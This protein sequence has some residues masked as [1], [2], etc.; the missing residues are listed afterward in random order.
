MPKATFKILLIGETQ[1]GC[2]TILSQFKKSYATEKNENKFGTLNKNKEKPKEEKDKVEEEEIKS[3]KQIVYHEN[4]K[5]MLDIIDHK[6]INQTIEEGQEQQEQQEQNTNLPFEDFIKEFHG[7]ILVYD[8]TKLSSS[9]KLKE[10]YELINKNNHCNYRSILLI[11]NKND[12][13]DEREITY[14][15]GEEFAENFDCL[16][17]EISSKDMIQLDSAITS[18][19]TDLVTK[20]YESMTIT[21]QSSSKSKKKFILP[22]KSGLSNRNCKFM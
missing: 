19:I 9:K 20:R 15:Q 16:F 6:F 5:Y 2:S 12:L 11:G 22:F 14:S 17:S 13:K 4:T 3:F 10:M 18:L 7:F 1:V 8:I 21:K